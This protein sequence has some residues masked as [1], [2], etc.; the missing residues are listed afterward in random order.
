VNAVDR[1]AN[2]RRRQGFSLIESLVACAVA[3]LLAGAALPSMQGQ[4][5]RAGRLD[6]V[7]ALTR[8]QAAQEQHHALH[9]F[10][11]SELGALGLINPN[12]P[13]GLYALS[14]QTNGPGAYHATATPVGRQ[15]KDRPCPALT[16][17]VN[18]GFPTE[19]PSSGC[20]QR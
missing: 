19:G 1:L 11:A 13:Q 8:V 15:A 5:L 10:Y 6:A 12:S 17:D 16:L 18:Q 4:R 2:R 9:G 20:W 14:L 3:A 7:A